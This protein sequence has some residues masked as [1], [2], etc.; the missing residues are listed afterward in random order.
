MSGN[1]THARVASGEMVSIHDDLRSHD[2]AHRL[3]EEKWAGVTTF[4]VAAESQGGH[5]AQG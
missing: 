3:L 4:R 1:A 2:H 5:K